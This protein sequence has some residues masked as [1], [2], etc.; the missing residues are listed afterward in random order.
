MR[1]EH[2]PI[3]C[4][5]PHANY[6]S[7]VH[8]P[9][10]S[11]GESVE[12][13][14]LLEI[15]S[16]PRTFK[17]IVEDETTTASMENYTDKDAVRSLQPMALSQDM[18]L[19]SRPVFGPFR[20]PHI[21]AG[22]T[23]DLPLSSMSVESTGSSYSASAQPCYPNASTITSKDHMVSDHQ[24]TRTDDSTDEVVPP[25]PSVTVA[26]VSK[27]PQ[28]RRDD[29]VQKTLQR[30]PLALRHNL[31]HPSP[32]HQPF[33][34][35]HRHLQRH[36]TTHRDPP[37][38][39]PLGTRGHDPERYTP[40]ETPCS[41]GHQVYP[42]V[43]P[44]HILGVKKP[45]HTKRHALYDT[46][47]Y[48]IENVEISS[49]RYDQMSRFQGSQD[50]DQDLGSDAPDNQPNPLRDHR[51]HIW[52]VAHEDEYA[53]D[54]DGKGDGESGGAVM[55]LS[56]ARQK[57]VQRCMPL[58]TALRLTSDRGYGVGSGTGGLSS[59]HEIVHGADSLSWSSWSSSGFEN[60]RD[61]AATRPIKPVS[62]GVYGPDSF[63]EFL[64]EPKESAAQQPWRRQCAA[65]VRR[66]WRSWL[67]LV[68]VLAIAAALAVVLAQRKVLKQATPLD[69]DVEENMKQ[70]SEAGDGD[71]GGATATRTSVVRPTAPAASGRPPGTT[72]RSV[73]PTVL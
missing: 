37:S 10:Y 52:V 66:Q 49:S 57:R 47:F 44:G 59:S 5:Y 55:L 35:P 22:E 9:D 29:V 28:P 18:P 41:P 60:D 36:Q 14:S 7:H 70:G 42:D 45:L 53:S 15:C 51:E 16:S 31:R 33:A 43:H 40:S 68:M 4:E 38:P 13:D 61:L 67:I 23:G 8:A 73:G 11:V 26:T 65:K 2:S 34:H 69:G 1:T 24:L 25:S 54:M 58:S 72:T 48:G 19:R 64:Q 56:E 21:P 62:Q 50:Q 12:P 27:S 6:F 71:R 46:P 39:L 17:S 30:P 20:S 32:H 63:V 3:A